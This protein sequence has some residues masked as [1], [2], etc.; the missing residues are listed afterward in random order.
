MSINYGQTDRYNDLA[1]IETDRNGG[2]T[3]VNIFRTR[4]IV[5]PIKIEVLERHPL[6]SQ[7]FMPLGQNPYLVVVAP[8]GPLE[9]EHI[10]VFQATANQ[11]VNYHKGTWHHFSLALGAKSDFLVIDRAGP[12]DNCDEVRL[13]NPFFISPS[14]NGA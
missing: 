11:G 14:A 1:R 10:K 4:P 8:S 12:E 13:K 2:R 7:A 5:P 9:E 6:S 3:L